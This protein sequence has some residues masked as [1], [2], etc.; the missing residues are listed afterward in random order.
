MTKR[1]RDA[2]ALRG[3]AR[4]AVSATHGVTDVVRD[5]HRAIG[6]GPRVLGQPL[7]G[8]VHAVTAVSYGAVRAVTSLVGAALE[9]AIDALAPWLGS[10]EPGPQ[11]EAA[12]AVLCGVVGDLLH[13]T[14]NP[15]AIAPALRS[16][17][18]ALTLERAALEEQFPQASSK[19]LVLV[20]GSSMNDLQWN[21]RGHD[22]GEALARE[23]GCTPIYLHYNSGRHVSDNGQL[24][25]QLL[26][27]L[28]TAWPKPVDEL[29]LLGHS[30]GGLVA[31]SAC[32]AAE[33]AGH[34]WRPKLRA[35]VCLGTPHHGAP[36]E[37]GGHWVDVLLGAFAHSAPLARLGK[38]RSAGVTDLRHGNVIE[39][40]WRGRDRFAPARDLRL[41]V[42]LPAGVS[43][44]AI[45]ARLASARTAPVVGDGLVPVDSALG[46]HPR[47]ELTLAF[48][49][50]QRWI[51]E[52]ADHLDLLD[53]PEVYARLRQWLA[54]AAPTTATTPSTM[55]PAPA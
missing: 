37:R 21:R 53:H 51:C 41:P 45:A 34:S 7:K 2:E 26:Q 38:I 11:R 30:M 15:L 14:G 25:S 46:R 23:L 8:P 47:A 12:T 48:P 49:E 3:A 1:D 17:G 33:S 42:P 27:E 4:L 36:L 35:L 40:H 28:V 39:S 19:L 52:D 22:H 5:M 24:F 29:L 10:S 44:Y 9:R 18:R 50:E 54:P 16:G 43:C 6:S 13:D 55:T 32:H 20:H 31:R